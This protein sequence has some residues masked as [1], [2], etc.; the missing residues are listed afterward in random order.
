[1]IPRIDGDMAALA[2]HADAIAAAGAGFAETGA[3]VH[4]SWQGLAAV[5]I[6]PEAGELLAAT[7]PIVSVTASVE[8][9]LL[10]VARALRLYA[11]EVAE[12]QRG[13]DALRV[14]AV[15]LAAL[16]PAAV[17]DG[18]DSELASAVATETLAWEEA[19]RRCAAAIR[20]VSGAGAAADVRTGDVVPAR[21]AS[22]APL[23]AATPAPVRG[24]STPALNWFDELADGAQ[25][26]G[27]AVVNGLASVG[28]AVVRNPGEAIAFVGGAT[29]AGVSSAGVAVGSGA[30]VTG[31]GAVV[32]VPLGGLSALG[33]ATGLG[34]AGVAGASIINS[35]MGDDRVE[36]VQPDGHA[37]ETEAGNADVGSELRSV[38]D[39]MANPQLLQGRSPEDVESV[40]GDTPGWRV[41]ALGRGR[42]RGTGLGASS[43]QRSW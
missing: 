2:G 7:G 10:A 16:P 15:D 9:D 20:A 27:A 42:K 19:Q 33:V 12:I 43:V 30:T 24:P 18:A 39:L 25:A 32:G 22:H 38:D 37:A 4:S 8:E 23:A 35:A 31:V 17:P 26:A 41:E 1:M 28:N 6:A 5:Y 36:P 29:L 13:F 11:A 21:F 14:R 3:A 34:I 40:I